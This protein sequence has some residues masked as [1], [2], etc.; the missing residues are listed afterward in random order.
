MRSLGSMLETWFKSRWH[1]FEMGNLGWPE[2]DIC[3]GMKLHVFMCVCV[4][5]CVCVYE[6]V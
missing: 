1:R 6:C 3:V 5:L 4:Y 2:H